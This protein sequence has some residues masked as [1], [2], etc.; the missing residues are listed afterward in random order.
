MTEQQARDDERRKIAAF[1][2]GFAN[3]MRMTN[4]G[5][6]AGYLDAIVMKLTHPDWVKDT[7]GH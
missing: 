1:I 2:Q 7:A 5:Y 4:Q 6:D 3:E